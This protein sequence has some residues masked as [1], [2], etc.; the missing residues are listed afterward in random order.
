MRRLP[1]MLCALA[2]VGT[3]ASA[4]A[5]GPEDECNGRPGTIIGTAGNDKLVGPPE[6]T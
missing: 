4:P 1:M 5:R 2:L 6:T 3:T